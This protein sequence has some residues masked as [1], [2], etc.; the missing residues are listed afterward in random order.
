MSFAYAHEAETIF[1]G[2][3]ATALNSREPFMTSFQF[4]GAGNVFIISFPSL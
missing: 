3:L 2:L 1:Y 4:L